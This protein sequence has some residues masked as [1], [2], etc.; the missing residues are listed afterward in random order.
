MG[1]LQEDMDTHQRVVENG[2]TL[3]V[4]VLNTLIYMY[5][6]YGSIEKASELFDKMHDVDIILWIAMIIGYAQDGCFEKTLD[7]FMQI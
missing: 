3:N 2:F 7:T 1:A 6:K 4:M 5:E